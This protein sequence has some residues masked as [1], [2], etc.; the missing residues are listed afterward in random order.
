MALNLVNSSQNNICSCLIFAGETYD[1]V[2]IRGHEYL[3]NELSSRTGQCRKTDFRE[4]Q[5]MCK[6]EVLKK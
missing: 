4:C 1:E 6:E 3:K 2:D 5:T